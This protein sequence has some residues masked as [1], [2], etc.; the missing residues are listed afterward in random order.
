MLRHENVVE[1]V[2]A[3]STPIS[4]FLTK[5]C[6][7][8]SLKSYLIKIERSNTRLSLSKVINF[9]LDIA[10]GMEYV[11][12][13]G[14]I[15]RDIKPDHVFIDHNFRLKI[16]DF[17]VSC[18]EKKNDF[19]KVGSLRCMAPEMISQNN[20]AYGVANKN[21]QSEVPNECPEFMRVLIERCCSKDPKMR[22]E[23][24]EIV[25][26]KLALIMDFSQL[27]LGKKFAEGAYG[28]IYHG[29]YSN[30]KVAVKILQV[31]DHEEDKY[32]SKQI[33][34]QFNEEVGFLSRLRHENV[35]EFVAACSTP[36]YCILTKFCSE[37]S[38][39]SYL[40]KIE[41][42]NTRLP[43]SKVINIGLDIARG[44][45][46]VHS[47]GVIHRDIKP[48]NVLI[49]H[50]FQLKIA[51]FGVSCEEKKNDFKKVGTLRWM[52][53]EMI[54]QNKYGRKVDVYS[55]GLILYE[56]VSGRVP[57][58]SL[59]PIQVAYGVANKNLKPEVPNECPEFMRVL[60]ER[61][62]C[63]DPKM[64]PEFWEIVKVLEERRANQKIKKGLLLFHFMQKFCISV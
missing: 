46:Y 52:A 9:G 30:K 14:V 63:K 44:M 12:S 15:H 53:P 51:D 42:S 47:R 3:C 38:L 23:F 55:F 16:A 13:R 26:N 6:S 8:G 1:F 37:G 54:S 43:L 2:A 24:W 59:N 21:L 48:D 60:I 4:N 56:M 33:H 7:K 57:F 49:D 22:P 62:C 58:G 34:K 39:K 25:K 10:R 36:V 28:K 50:N 61:C 35:V 32:K 41:R 45:E 11:H 5:F 31:H 17:G 18:E 19:K 27:L 29:L 64:R 40:T 20:Y